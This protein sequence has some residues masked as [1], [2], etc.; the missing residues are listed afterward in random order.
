[1]ALQVIL[2]LCTLKQQEVSD[3]NRHACTG[4]WWITPTASSRWCSSRTSPPTPCCRAPSPFAA[5]SPVATA[6]PSSSGD[7]EEGMMSVTLFF[8]CCNHRW[9][10]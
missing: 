6:R 3:S 5:S 7:G 4:T 8:L 2:K 1:M 9:R 10:D